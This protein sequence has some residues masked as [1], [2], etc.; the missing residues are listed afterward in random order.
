MERKTTAV[1]AALVL[2]GLV[3]RAQAA[4]IERISTVGS[5]AAFEFNASTSITC[6]DGSPGVANLLAFVSAADSINKTTG[7][8]QSMSNGVS[9]EVFFYFNSCTGAFIGFGDGG[10]PNSYT[11]PDKKLTSAAI[12][13]SGTV[14]DFDFGNT[15]PFSMNVSFTGTGST[16]QEKSSSHSKVIGTKHGN[17]SISNNQSANSSRGATV[18][19]TIGIENV[20]FSSFDVFFASMTSNASNTMTVSK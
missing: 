14:Q 2:A 4:E 11:A 13:G 6:A 7:S 9:M 1:L 17:L 8:P 16:N 18:T 20:T 5:Q 12:A 3:G 19:G 15:Y 10:I